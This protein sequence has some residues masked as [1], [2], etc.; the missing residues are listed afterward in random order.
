MLRFTERL[1]FVGRR[2]FLFAGAGLLLAQARPLRAQISGAI[3]EEFS[4]AIGIRQMALEMPL[5]GIEE[6]LIPFIAA[7]YEARRATLQAAR[8]TG[9][10]G[11]VASAENHVA[12]LS[13]TNLPVTFEQSTLLSIREVNELISSQGIE[14]APPPNDVTP[15]HI[16]SLPPSDQNGGDSDIIVVMDIILETLGISTDDADLAVMLI[17]SNPELERLVSNTLAAITQQDWETVV[18][19]A[20]AVFDFLVTNRQIRT[21][22]GRLLGRKFAFR[23]ALRCVP[24]VGWLYTGA[25]FVVSVK[26][27]YHR[28][29]FG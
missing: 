1:S 29:S 20:E 9:S 14:L 15:A 21:V 10:F 2:S 27:N 22:L 12:Q 23:L 4:R 24:V 18:S 6:R 26:K 28:F 13:S 8:Q 25:L 7:D 17:R 19:S 3:V 5:E 16:P 11:D